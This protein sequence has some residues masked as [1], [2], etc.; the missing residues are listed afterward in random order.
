MQDFATGKAAAR[1]GAM[2]KLN[3]SGLLLKNYRH[4]VR[5]M[6][7]TAFIL[8]AFCLQVAAKTK[9][10]G[11]IT[12]KEKGASIIKVMTE[13]QRQTG[14][15]FLVT[16]ETI[17]RAKPIDIEVKDAP[18]SQVLEIVFKNQPL[19]YT[20][21]DKLITIRLKAENK[22]SSSQNISSTGDP[23]TVSGK[24]TDENGQPLVG[25]NVKV[26]GS[27]AGVTTDNEGR[28]T[29]NNV[30]PNATL[31]ISFVGHETQ[32]LS[33]KG[34][35]V[36]TVALGQKVGTL[37]ET[38]VIGYG[39]TTKRFN[40][41]NV[42]SVKASDI[43]KQPI[44]NPLLALQGRIPG[45]EITQSTGLPGSGIVVQIRGQN[46]ISQGNYPL[47]IVDG[48]PYVSYNL[49][50]L[51][52]IL[53]SSGG[54]PGIGSVSGNP[55]SY[56]NPGDIESIEV[57]KD[58]DATSIYGS[59]GANGVVLITTKK[60]KV[61]KT[62]LNVN[63]QTGWGKVTRK[64]KL[65]NTRQY[66]EMRREALRNDGITPSISNSPD[67]LV[68]DTTSFTDWQRVLI[69]GTMRFNN[70]QGSISGGSENNQFLLGGSYHKE[71][72]VF[73][74]NFGDRKA[75]INFNFNNSSLNKKFKVLLSGN[76]TVDN[77]N[78]SGFDPTSLTTT[79]APN[80]PALYN[81]D[82]SL[83]W[84]LNPS[85]SSTW[86]NPI[87]YLLRKFKSHTN[88]LVSN[89]TLNYQ[90][91][92]NI[93]IK[94]S[95]GYNNIQTNESHTVPLTYYNPAF[96]AT[97]QRN[98]TYANNSIRSWII[99]PQVSYDKQIWKGRLNLLLG[100]TFLE[101]TSNGEIL[102]GRGFNSD[103]VLEDK[104]SAATVTVSSSINSKYK[105]NA[106]FGRINYNIKDKYLINLTARRDGSSRFGPENRFH[107]FGAIGIGW[108]FSEENIIL[109]DLPFIS[110]GKVR[111][112]YGTTGNDQI[113]E[114]S[115]YDLYYSTNSTFPY[116][117]TNGLLINNLFNPE[118]AWE[119]TRKLEAGF[120]LG[121]FK[122]K[123]LLTSSFYLNRSS[124]QLTS[125]T[126]PF[127]TGFTSVNKNLEASLQNSG[128]EFTLSTVNVNTKSIRWTSSVNL[129]INRNKL[130]SV[131]SAIGDFY[132][133]SVGRSLNGNFVYRFSGVDAATGIYQVADVHGNP[134]LTPDNLNDATVFV[135]LNPKFYGGFQN[136]VIFKGIQFDFV[137][138]FVKQIGNNYF[139]GNNPGLAR[140]NQ[141]IT[142]LDRWQKP[143]DNVTIQ[144]YSS[145]SS[146]NQQ[147][148]NAKSSDA[149][150][151]DASFIRLKNI[152]ISWQLPEKWRNKIR[153]QNCRVYI[154][155]QNLLTITDY[156]GMD[157]ETRSVNS[158]P[159]LRILTT[160]LQITL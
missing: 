8:L 81:S 24:V 96:W 129:T 121:L 46:S 42:S 39:T 138:Q 106:F 87:T 140:F 34:K 99:E 71:T 35:T 17:N 36:F 59:R 10:Q 120:E 155:G 141:P 11:N 160:G 84:A 69:G 128:W 25:A 50:N 116:Q 86:T 80:A 28:F 12:L 144:K 18:L 97:A 33:V 37:D 113:G 29:L 142:V 143:N 23:V 108:I 21:K 152:S 3:C 26:K 119:E 56:L 115:F 5:I 91:S 76:Y 105:Y 156:E 52:E 19:T 150:F 147:F 130:I 104:K 15:D 38:V 92:K 79:L 98:A 62:K 55:L 117:G 139:F 45:M 70:I 101:T 103:L 127:T 109:R 75:S 31:E 134:T 7:I 4:A 124:N 157:P 48:V 74:G 112:S 110:Y 53:G 159:P 63:A 146:I 131:D 40:T 145:N 154:Q 82:G 66:L 83:N 125:Y 100:T 57:L 132:T 93:E 13:V 61:G 126:L 47:Y 65:L 58:A 30:D 122:D 158:L 149:A 68:W 151:T 22:V 148:N 78:L 72:T 137:A 49:P 6:K 44:N 111:C 102:S 95:L 43:E 9:A 54:V 20:I 123:I 32:T 136:T 114:Y 27:N 90:I 133:R 1:G 85:G 153:L 88:N 77:N 94:S 89:A 64:L 107:N 118:L 41:G 16:S 135:D 60:G 2:P 67:L 73:P 14:Y 51:G